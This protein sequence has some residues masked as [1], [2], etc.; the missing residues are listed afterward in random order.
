M[1]TTNTLSYSAADTIEKV[2]NGFEI[3]INRYLFWTGV[4]M[5]LPVYSVAILY[6]LQIIELSWDEGVNLFIFFIA[7]QVLQHFVGFFVQLQLTANLRN[8]ETALK[9]SKPFAPGELQEAW[10]ETINLPIILVGVMT[11]CLSVVFLL[12]PIVLYTV[13]FMGIDIWKQVCAAGIAG[14]SIL[15]MLNLLMY[16]RALSPVLI[17]IEKHGRKYI[18]RNDKRIFFVSL[19]L[20][21]VTFFGVTMLVLTFILDTVFYHEVSGIANTTLV[22]ENIINHFI[23]KVLSVS[24][25]VLL[26]CGALIYQLAAHQIRPIS[27]IKRHMNLLADGEVDQIFYSGEAG[28]VRDEGNLMAEVFSDMTVELRNVLIWIRHA[29]FRLKQ[30]STRLFSQAGEFERHMTD[31]EALVAGLEQLVAEQTTFSN[32]Q[33]AE[34]SVIVEQM[35]YLLEEA[36]TGQ[37]MLQKVVEG[38]GFI[39]TEAVR[40]QVQIEILHG[41]LAEIDEVVAIIRKVSNQ[42][43]VLAFN[44]F[45]EAAEETAGE[46]YDQIAESIHALTIQITDASQKVRNS[47]QDV[48]H[49]SRTLLTLTEREHALVEAETYSTQN[50]QP[51]LNQ[52]NQAIN[53]INLNIKQ[54]SGATRQQSATNQKFQETIVYMLQQFDRIKAGNTSITNEVRGLHRDVDNLQGTMK[55]FFPIKSKISSEQ[56]K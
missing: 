8:F 34:F 11:V 15:S 35:D 39:K 40:T 22:T 51:M 30:E 48:Q 16:E 38:I 5:S 17:M 10:I 45:L 33:H 53:A 23:L 26:I 9:K 4:K 31:Q 28:V 44:A 20:K 43:Q 56:A 7:M 37:V 42:T 29:G 19:Q 12:L 27:K 50:L 3:N 36:S 32:R 25:A 49:Y 1:A 2:S 41:K 47:I 18:D 21:F 24:L 54:I 55:S 46:S 6:L 14:I 13:Y 52:I